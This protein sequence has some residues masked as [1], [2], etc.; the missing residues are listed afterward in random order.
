MPSAPRDDVSP[1]GD[2]D[3]RVGSGASNGVGDR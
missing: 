3:A 2:R 1:V